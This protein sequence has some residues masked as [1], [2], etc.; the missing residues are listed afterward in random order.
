MSRQASEPFQLT[1][2][3]PYRLA[4]RSERV[5]M[6]VAQLYSHRFDVTR[7]EWRVLAALAVNNAMTPKEIIAYSTLEKMQVSRAVAGLEEKGA[8][9]RRAQILT[10]TAAGRAL[11]KTIAPIARA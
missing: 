5:S 6:A 11:F 7:A 2:F 8:T 10:L 1:D 9:D 4:V 3:F